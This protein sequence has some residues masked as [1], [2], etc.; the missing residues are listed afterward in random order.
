LINLH[1]EIIGLISSK[2]FH[3]FERKSAHCDL[4]RTKSVVFT[5]TSMNHF[6][7]W[8]GIRCISAHTM[9]WR[10]N[11]RRWYLS[12]EYLRARILLDF[13]HNR[14]VYLIY[15]VQTSYILNSTIEFDYSIIGRRRQFWVT[16]KA[17]L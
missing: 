1:A 14:M 15:K 11:L 3:V 8:Q 4:T 10:R 9:C 12:M 13:L 7:W 5:K 6:F 16:V 17:S 2:L